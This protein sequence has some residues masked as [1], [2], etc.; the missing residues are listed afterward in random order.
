MYINLQL[1]FF[2][3]LMI[4]IITFYRFNYFVDLIVLVTT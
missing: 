4:N 1:C 2:F 3:K